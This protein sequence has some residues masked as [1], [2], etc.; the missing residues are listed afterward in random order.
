MEMH[1]AHLLSTIQVVNAIINVNTFAQYDFTRAEC[2]DG[3]FAD[4]MD[5][6]TYGDL[7]LGETASCLDTTVGIQPSN[8]T[9]GRPAAYS[10]GNSSGFPNALL[11]EPDEYPGFA[12]EVWMT[13]GTDPNPDYPC[14]HLSCEY[15][16][17]SIHNYTVGPTLDLCG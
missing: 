3:V 11:L 16:V 7:I 14:E 6:G 13:L 10:L 17:L 9:G 2:D 5:D 1:L 15:V 8:L 12:V 4:V